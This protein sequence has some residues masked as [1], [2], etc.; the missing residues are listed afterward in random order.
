L[1]A[2]AGTQE[3]VEK[4]DPDWWK[5]QPD[6]KK[7]ETAINETITNLCTAFTAKDTQKVLS[8]IAPDDREK[9][10]T[11]FSK[12]PDIMPQIA[13]DMEKATL[14]F[15]SLDADNTLDRVAEYTMKIDGNTFYIVFIKIEGKWLIKNF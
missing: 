14:S 2:A 13:K 5:K 7:E 3:A 10:K 9:F 15:L 4:G 1:K 6:L 8:Y 12:S 11:I